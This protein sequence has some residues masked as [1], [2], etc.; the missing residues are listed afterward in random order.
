MVSS[1]QHYWQW[2]CQPQISFQ[3]GFRS[4][5]F[6]QVLNQKVQAWWCIQH[7]QLPWAGLTSLSSISKCMKNHRQSSGPAQA[8]E[9]QWLLRTHFTEGH[10]SSSTLSHSVWYLRIKVLASPEKKRTNQKAYFRQVW[11]LTTQ[12]G[13]GHKRSRQ[14]T[15]HWHRMPR[16]CQHPLCI[17]GTQIAVLFPKH[18][19][20][21]QTPAQPGNRAPSAAQCSCSTAC[22]LCSLSLL[23]RS[24]LSWIKVQP[25][26]GSHLTALTMEALSLESCYKINT[27]CTTT[28]PRCSSS[29]GGLKN[30][31]FQQITQWHCQEVGSCC[32]NCPPMKEVPR[33]SVQQ[34]SEINLH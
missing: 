28:F 2:Q 31:P 23:L 7:M 26:S 33:G 27:I 34:A 24:D 21:E 11:T 20:Q 25:T 30:L 6:C 22:P 1:R 14:R 12:V 5:G 16:L 19:R 4:W 15:L 10:G 18:K 9:L 8:E 13:F 29:A 32:K 3:A 17:W